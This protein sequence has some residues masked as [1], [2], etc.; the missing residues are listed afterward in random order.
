M[1]PIVE[2]SG[3]EDAFQAG[4]RLFAE[5][6]L[7]KSHEKLVLA[8]VR[9]PQMELY[10]LHEQFVGSRVTGKFEDV[11]ETRALASKL[12]R[13]DKTA[14]FASYVL[15]YV[16]LEQGDDAL[17]TKH[18]Q[19]AFHL[20][21]NL[22]DAGRQL[23]RLG[24]PRKRISTPAATWTPPAKAAVPS[25]PLPRRRTF[26]LLGVLAVLLTVGIGSV[27]ATRLGMFSDY[28]EVR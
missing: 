11:S 10:R 15:G 8:C 18:F 25:A 14:A 17:A 16:G 23:R 12:A 5:G 1:D 19:N 28:V 20:D 9:A 27:A 6:K 26:A 2:F 21:R 22:L 3:V 13:D 4:K 24:E 7:E